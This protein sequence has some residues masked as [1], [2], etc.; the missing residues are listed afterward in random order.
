MQLAKLDLSGNPKLCSEIPPRFATLHRLSELKLGGLKGCDTALKMPTTALSIKGH[1]LD[2]TRKGRED[3]QSFFE[4]LLLWPVAK[5]AFRPCAD[6]GVRWDQCSVSKVAGQAKERGVVAGWVCIECDGIKTCDFDF[7]VAAQLQ[8]RRNLNETPEA[9]VLH[10]KI[11]RWSSAARGELHL[12]FAA[13]APWRCG[14]VRVATLVGWVLCE[15]VRHR[16]VRHGQYRYEEPRKSGKWKPFG[17]LLAWQLEDAWRRD[18]A[19]V[20]MLRTRIGSNLSS[21]GEQVWPNWMYHVVECCTARQHA[22]NSV[23]PVALRCKL[24]PVA[25][26]QIGLLS[27]DVRR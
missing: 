23:L 7:E 16:K 12:S 1:G 24:L 10:E 27:H 9:A 15:L 26:V 6:I 20:V 2:P 5:V 11:E 25:S 19:A 4:E 22:T 8:Q 14:R 17:P 18:P 3:V 13:P 21:G